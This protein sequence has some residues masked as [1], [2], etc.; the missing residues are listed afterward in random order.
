MG[1]PRHAGGPQPPLPGHQHVAPR[2]PLDAE[3]LEDPVLP[4][5]LRQLPEGLLVKVAAGLPG[6]GHDL[7]DG[8]LVDPP[9]LEQL[10][11]FFLHGRA[12]LLA[13]SPILACPSG[14]SPQIPSRAFLF[15]GERLR[16][17]KET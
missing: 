17:E 15:C 14:G 3:G 9:G 13:S 12:S 2:R 8:Q 5:R 7:V 10:P 11:L 4:D 6:V 16:D 1:E